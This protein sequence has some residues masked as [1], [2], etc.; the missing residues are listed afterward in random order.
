MSL[1]QEK[2]A[3]AEAIIEAHNSALPFES[4]H[5]LSWSEIHA[6]LLNI[7]ATTEETLRHLTWED[8]QD[9]GIPKVLARRIAAEVFRSPPT[10]STTSDT[11]KKTSFR[12]ITEVRASIMP[13]EELLAAYDPTGE[14]NPAVTNRLRS[15]TSSSK[16]PNPRFIV[17]NP[18]GSVNVPESLSLLKEI[19]AGD[20]ERTTLHHEPDGVV[21]VYRLGERPGDLKHENPLLPGNP[22]RD[23]PYTNRSWENIP[24][25]VRQLIYLAHFGYGTVPSPG[26][27]AY[28]NFVNDLLDRLEGPSGTVEAV[29]RRYPDAAL[30]LKELAL[31]D[32]VPP[33]K[34]IRGTTSAPKPNNPFNLGSHRTT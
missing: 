27:P 19:R 20:P 22:L 7:G 23:D 33:L 9:A 34:V 15:L 24:F 16:N 3:A 32:K 14:V 8:L 28:I 12:P 4:P 30:E 25:E 26:T 31:L 10:P 11:T 5:H 13:P 21:P 1:Y 17:F 6:S 29:S 18:D 2:M